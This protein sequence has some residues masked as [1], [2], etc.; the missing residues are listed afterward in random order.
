MPEE[1]DAVEAT[2][3]VDLEDESVCVA[4]DLDHLV[5]GDPSPL[6]LLLVVM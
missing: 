4:G 3:I 6:L 2:Q 5:G 1:L